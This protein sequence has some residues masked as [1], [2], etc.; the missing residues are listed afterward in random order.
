MVPASSGVSYGND[1]DDHELVRAG[2][3]SVLGQ[4]DTI[5]VIADAGDGNTAVRLA[6]ELMPD[7]GIMNVDLP[8]LN[9]M[10]ASDPK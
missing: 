4:D 2:L 1:V 8:G 10:D 6:R 9:A 7:L 5:D 3:R